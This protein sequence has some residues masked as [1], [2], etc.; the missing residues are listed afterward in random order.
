MGLLKM[1]VENHESKVLLG[2]TDCIRQFRPFVLAELWDNENRVNASAFFDEIGGY[3][4]KASIN[5]RL[6]PMDIKNPSCQNFF[7]IP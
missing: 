3:T 6:V 7:F 5:K 4:C 2:S 1:D